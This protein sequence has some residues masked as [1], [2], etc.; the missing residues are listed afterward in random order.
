VA[1]GSGVAVGGAGV[2]VR[3]GLGV[4]VLVIR[5]TTG[6]SVGGGFGVF[7]EVAVGAGNACARKL[8]PQANKLVPSTTSNMIHFLFIATNCTWSDDQDKSEIA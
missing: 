2:G 7:V 6:V 3:D 5:S 1:D 8:G 4:G